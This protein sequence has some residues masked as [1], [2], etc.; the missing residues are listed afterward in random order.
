MSRLAMSYSNQTLNRLPSV[1]DSKLKMKTCL[2]YATPNTSA[3]RH[4]LM[5]YTCFYVVW[6]FCRQ[7]R[8]Y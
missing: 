2:M 1:Y 7:I 4:N 8:Q 3:Q 5:Y 6:H